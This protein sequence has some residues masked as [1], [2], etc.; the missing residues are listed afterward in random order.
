M[1]TADERQAIRT[2]IADLQPVARTTLC[3]Y[4]AAQLTTSDPQL[5]L[6]LIL[7][8]MYRREAH[9][10]SAS[11]YPAPPQDQLGG[12]L[13]DFGLRLTFTYGDLK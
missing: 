5:L 8:E 10:C 13:S 7:D 3:R 1:S 9:H 11:G 6:D 4:F 2:I 12:V